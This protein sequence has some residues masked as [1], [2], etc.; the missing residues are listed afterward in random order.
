LQVAEQQLLHMNGRRP[1]IAVNV[2]TWW[3]S[4]FFVLESQLQSR[5]ALQVAA[6]AETWAELPAGSK[7]GHVRKLLMSA[8]YWKHA[9]LLVKL[10]QPFADAIHQLE[11]DRP[12]LVDCHLALITLRKHVVVWSNKFRTSGLAAEAPCPFTGRAV[13]T[14]DRRLD[15]QVRGALAPVYNAAYSAAYALDPFYADVEDESDGPFCSAPTMSTAHLEEARALVLR[16]GGATAAVQ[17]ARLFTQGYPKS[18]QSLVAGTAGERIK[19]AAMQQPGRKRDRVVVPSSK[20]RVAVWSKFGA[21]I[22]ELRDVAV[23]LLSAHATTAA[24]E[25]NWSLWGRTYCAAR[26]S[27]GME[28]AKALIAICSAEKAKIPLSE[29]F[30]IT[31]DVL[32]GDVTDV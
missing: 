10:L 28:R 18:M 31:L 13:A 15:A 17:F 19:A 16:V 6:A 9:D 14:V 27:L 24:S 21:D 5:T 20:E 1:T 12:H 7:A 25:R 22:S 8:D 26:S 4:N 29:A 2:P 3:A 11:G 23:R 30:Q 32:D